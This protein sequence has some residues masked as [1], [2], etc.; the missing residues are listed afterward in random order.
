MAPTPSSGDGDSADSQP[1]GSHTW[2]G[3]GK[4]KGTKERQQHHRQGEDADRTRGKGAHREWFKGKAPTRGS[5]PLV[6]GTHALRWRSSP[7]SAV[8]PR[9]R[10]NGYPIRIPNAPVAWPAYSPSRTT[11]GEKNKRKKEKKKK[12][13]GK[14]KEKGGKPGHVPRARRPGRQ[15]RIARGWRRGTR[16]RTPAPPPPPTQSLRRWPTGSTG[17]RRRPGPPSPR[18]PAPTP[19]GR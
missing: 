8:P 6:A 13:E 10:N 17:K 3:A 5:G 2:Y 4:K 7:L 1:V 16:K 9:P 12:E 19:S 14:E 11:T 18:R 15:T